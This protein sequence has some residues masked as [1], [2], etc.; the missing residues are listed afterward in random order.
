MKSCIDIL[1]AS[2]MDWL[3]T[4]HIRRALYLL[5]GTFRPVRNSKTRTAGESRIGWP[6]MD[7]PEV[8]DVYK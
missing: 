7:R 3:F 6:R 8:V 2:T 5:C 1:E 4:L